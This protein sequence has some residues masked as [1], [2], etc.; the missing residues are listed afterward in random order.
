MKL[1]AYIGMR[2]AK[3]WAF[4][5]YFIAS[6]EKWL[7]WHHPQLEADT[8]WIYSQV[9]YM[10]VNGNYS[11]VSVHRIAASDSDLG[12]VQYIYVC[13]WHKAACLGGNNS[14]FSAVVI[15]IQQSEWQA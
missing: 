10:L 5:K 6:L 9:C 13:F 14:G 2:F 12:C 4:A 7:K 3:L 8:K 15:I 1:L 11:Q